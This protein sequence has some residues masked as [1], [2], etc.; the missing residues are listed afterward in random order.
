MH[1]R[2]TLLIVRLDFGL[3]LLRLFISDL[4]CRSTFR[5]LVLHARVRDDSLSDATVLLAGAS[6]LSTVFLEAVADIN[7]AST[8]VLALHLRDCIVWTLE[9]VKAHEAVLFW[10]SCLAISHNL[11][12]HNNTKLAENILELFLVYSG[13]QISHEDVCS[14]LL[15]ALVLRRF[16]HLDRLVEELDH[17]QKFDWVV[18]VLFGLKLDEAEVLVFLGKCTCI[19]G[20]AYR[21]SSQSSSSLTR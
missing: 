19:T 12:W 11:G 9:I 7:R 5:L 2:H 13:G 3:K 20:P 4:L 16:V 6:H 1:L 10:F 14:D 17:V 15:R 8:Q 18:G 21:K